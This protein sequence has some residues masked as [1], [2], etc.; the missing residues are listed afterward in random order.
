MTPPATAPVIAGL[1]AALVVRQ[2][3]PQSSRVVVIVIRSLEAFVVVTA[4]F[5]TWRFSS[6]A[7]LVVLVLFY[8]T[9]GEARRMVADLRRL[10]FLDNLSLYRRLR[11]GQGTDEVLLAALRLSRNRIGA[12]IAMERGVGLEDY[13]ATGVRIN[14]ELSAAFLEAMFSPR[15]ALHDGA[16]I[17]R[18]KTVL[19]A[20]CLLPLA[21]ESQLRERLGTRHRAAIGLSLATD[22]LTLV[23]SEATGGISLVEDGRITQ[24]MDL[25]SLRRFLRVSPTTQTSWYVSA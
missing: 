21:D 12:L 3:L 2:L 19:A 20:G 10:R 4:V 14:A 18:G 8:L 11:F 7:W 23:V 6:T 15:S 1:V 5:L 16:V 13:A 22:A 17:V 9:Q 24:N 25:D